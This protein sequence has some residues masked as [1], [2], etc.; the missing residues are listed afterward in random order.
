[1][2]DSPMTHCYLYSMAF[3][4]NIVFSVFMRRY[5]NYSLCFI[6]REATNSVKRL[7]K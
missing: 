2:R 3:E 5:T 1:M 4:I 7:N 6:A